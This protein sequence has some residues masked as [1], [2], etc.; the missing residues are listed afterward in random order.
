MSARR[1]EINLQF[2]QFIDSMLL[3]GVFWFAHFI[4]FNRLVILDNL[5]T[6]DGFEKFVW[7][8]AV[9]MPFGPFVLEMQGFYNYPLEKTAWKSM[10]QMAA[11]GFWMFVILGCAVIFL[12]LDVPSR[13]VLILFGILAP[14]ALLLRE[15]LSVWHYVGMLRRGAVGE[16]IIV[17]GE[18]KTMEELVDS[19]TPAQKLE[20]Q[21]VDS[22]DLEVQGIETLVEALHK[23]AVGRVILTFHHMELDK[24]QRAIEACEIEGV[25][26]WLNADFIHT[27]VAR[28]S[29]E[30]LGKKP[31]L[32][33][34]VSPEISWAIL[35]KSFSDRI[36]AALGLVGFMGQQA[37]STA[38]SST[39]ASTSAA[40][41][42]APSTSAT[43]GASGISATPTTSATTST[44]ATSSASSISASAA[45]AQATTGGS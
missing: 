31:M 42:S 5:W 20:V 37:V 2:N 4:R 32:V 15:R 41:T 38:A 39:A 21:V 45:P 34:R 13:S 16:R 11:A 22:I 1:H 26:A 27:S 19:L 36:L 7:I 43:T 30:I 44:P 3:G 40:G 28:P 8:L 33:F 14:I 12:R 18:R 24:V 6:I 25:E 35:L 23:H 29:Y 9:I 17:A 10:R